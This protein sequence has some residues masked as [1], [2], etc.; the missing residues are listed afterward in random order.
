MFYPVN[1]A[2]YAAVLSVIMQMWV[3][4]RKAACHRQW[5]MAYNSALFC[6]RTHAGA[7]QDVSKRER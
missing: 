2:K 5:K 1:K 4:E 7:R 3:W 6:D